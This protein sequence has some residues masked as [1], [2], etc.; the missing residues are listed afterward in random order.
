MATQAPS[1]LDERIGA[2]VR[3]QLHDQGMSQQAL[4]DRLEVSAFFISRR[5]RGIVPFTV[6]ELGTVAEVLH[7]PVE[8]LMDGA[9]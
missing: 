2:K 9:A 3:E 8:E 6:A 1:S 5:L 4:A 7:V